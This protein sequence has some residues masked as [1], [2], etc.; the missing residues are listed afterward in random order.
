MPTLNKQKQVLHS[1]QES[2]YPSDR[3]ARCPGPVLYMRGPPR[4]FW[5]YTIGVCRIR[6][7]NFGEHLF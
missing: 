3:V 2:E 7:T 5:T 4:G 1:I 6:H